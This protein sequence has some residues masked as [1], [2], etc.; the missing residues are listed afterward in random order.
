MKIEA[1]GVAVPEKFTTTDIAAK[2]TPIETT[3]ISP[4]ITLIVLVGRYIS[5]KVRAVLFKGFY[6]QLS[7][8]S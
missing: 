3:L 2:P 1:P 7:V 4:R 6:V 5:P 8:S